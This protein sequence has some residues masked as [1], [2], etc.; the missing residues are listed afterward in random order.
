M[1][2]NVTYA[3]M[4]AEL[5][6]G[7]RDIALGYAFDLLQWLERDGYVPAAAEADGFDRKRLVRH[8]RAV[9]DVANE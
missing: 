2:P 6:L 8:C 7:N 3:G 5:R 4:V 9:C 1:D